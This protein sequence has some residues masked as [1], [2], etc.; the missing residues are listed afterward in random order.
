MCFFHPS[1]FFYLLAAGLSSC[2]WLR[3]TQG[4]HPDPIRKFG[5]RPR[6]VARAVGVESGTSAGGGIPSTY[7]HP[8]PCKP[9]RT[10]YIINRLKKCPTSHVISGILN[11]INVVRRYIPGDGKVFPWHQHGRHSTIYI[12]LN[13]SLILRTSFAKLINHKQTHNHPYCVPHLRN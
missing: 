9:T 6:S 1:A 11:V 5:P 12:I 10:K 3:G 4:A 7:S 13:D 2:S 8:G